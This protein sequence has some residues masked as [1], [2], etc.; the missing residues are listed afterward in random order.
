MSE[1]CFVVVVEGGKSS[2]LGSFRLKYIAERKLGR[3][4]SWMTNQFFQ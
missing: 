1:K 3:R 4:K 2:F